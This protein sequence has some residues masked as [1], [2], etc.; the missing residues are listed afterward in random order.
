MNP[1]HSSAQPPSYDEFT[2]PPSGDA[3][4]E[5]EG[6]LT[7]NQRY[8]RNSRPFSL[9]GLAQN[10]WAHLSAIYLLWFVA[11]VISCCAMA[12]ANKNAARISDLE[13]SS[14]S[15][16]RHASYYDYYAHRC[17]IYGDRLYGDIVYEFE[18]HSYQL[19][20]GNWA[21][22]MWREAEQDAWGRCY[23]NSPGYLASIDSAD[24]NN[25]LQ[26][27]LLGHPGYK[28]G[29]VAW[30]GGNDMTNEGTFEWIDGYLAK[31]IFE[32]PGAEKDAFTNWAPGEPNNNG[33]EDCVS[34]NPSGKWND[35]NCYKEN[36]FFFVEFDSA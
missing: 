16:G 17:E 35:E 3:L 20:G 10:V 25:F 21:K 32:G 4:L 18:G 15:G 11:F 7:S 8:Q 5:V 31:T 26:G 1:I 36:Q 34:F 24:E 12:K 27:I 13:S 6:G 28:F 9:E 30:I 33:E 14:S 19:I 2:S 29:D 23:K 22:L